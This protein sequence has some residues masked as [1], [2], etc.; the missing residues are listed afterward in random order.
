MNEPNRSETIATY[1]GASQQEPQ[2]LDRIVRTTTPHI[3][4]R[5]RHSGA[6]DETLEDLTVETVERLVKAVRRR[7][8]RAEIQM[9]D[10]IR[11]ALAV[12]DTVFDDYIRL[13]RPQW[14]RLKRRVIYLIDSPKHSMIFKRWKYRSEWI[15]G[16]TRW[17]NHPFRPNA[18]YHTL[19]SQPDSFC[20]QELHDHSPSEL[21][22][23]RLMMHLFRWLG[24]P[25]EVDELTTRIAD[26]QEIKD[27]TP[28]S[29]DEMAQQAEREPDF[30][31]PPSEEDVERFV[32]D[33]LESS[34]FCETLRL[35]I[36]EL[37]LRQRTALL[38]GMTTDEM[39]LIGTLSALAG[40]L[41]IPLEELKALWTGLPLDDATIAQ[42]L[43]ITPKQVSN[44]RKCA[45]ERLER[46]LKPKLN[47]TG[48]EQKR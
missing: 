21:S 4:K 30:W 48:G 9:S 37:P 18:R 35:L 11:Y 31:I 15:A 29:L 45:R 26:L 19:C 47:R 28:L 17:L 33:S 46:N 25:V 12:A 44:L 8:A 38:L 41:Q 27:N 13:Q 16:F 2:Y 39:L 40:L 7:E 43:D 22:L 6:S 23:D 24:I 36:A 42:R 1:H 20:H 3:R 32:L 10:P 34:T 5:L 14:A